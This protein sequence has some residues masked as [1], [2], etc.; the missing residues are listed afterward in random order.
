MVSSAEADLVEGTITKF[1]PGNQFLRYLL[2]G[3][4]RGSFE[5][6]WH[7]RNASGEKTGECEIKG[8]ITMGVFGGDF[9]EVLKHVG[10]ELARCL[11]GDG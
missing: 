11:R 5:S 10:E 3:L 7:V 8:S 9:D 1:S 2:P 6:T 4:G